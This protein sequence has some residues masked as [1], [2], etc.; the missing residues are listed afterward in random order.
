MPPPPCPP[1]PVP[2]EAAGSTPSGSS[3][4][5]PDTS[6]LRLL[7]QQ[8]IP[9]PKAK[10]KTI[11]WNK[12]PNNKVCWRVELLDFFAFAQASRLFMLPF[13][14]LGGWQEQYLVACCPVPT[15]LTSCGAWLG[16][17]G[18]FILPTSPTCTHSCSSP[19]EDGQRI[20]RYGPS[21]E[22]ILGGTVSVVPTSVTGTWLLSDNSLSSFYTV[23]W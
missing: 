3:P 2:Q 4:E 22:G 16:R 14:E 6:S 20:A 19:L 7:P 8:E 10:M 15:R 12:I 23:L 11:N 13:Y 5:P 1:P 18:R 9:T 17:N 21:S